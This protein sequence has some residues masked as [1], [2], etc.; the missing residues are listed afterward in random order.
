[1]AGCGR[2]GWAAALALVV[3]TAACADDDD[4]AGG[5]GRTGGTE[6]TGS[7]VTE[8]ADPADAATT[9]PTT[10]APTASSAEEPADPGDAEAGDAVPSDLVPVPALEGPITG[11]TRGASAN[12]MPIG[13]AEEAGY[14]EEEWFLTGEARAF[15]L[16][17]PAG[18]DGAWTAEP[19][20]VAPYRTR[21]IVRRPADPD[22]FSGT[23]VV[24][25]LNVTAGRD[26]DP[27]FGFLHPELLRSGYAYVGVSAQ[28]G[29]L[30]G[31]GMTLEVPGVDPDQIAPLQTWDPERYGSLDHPGDAFSYDIFSQ[32]AQAVL[33]HGE[34]DPLDGLAVDHVL[35]MGE[36]QSAFRLVTYVDAVH[37]VSQ[38]F[39]GFLLHSRGGFGAPLSDDPADAIPETVTIRTDLQEP[40]LQFE[41]ET[42]LVRLGFLAA[43]QPDGDSVVTW[44]V[45]GTAHA[46]RS[47]LEYG[48]ASGEARGSSGGFDASTFCGSVN[49]GPQAPVLRAALVALRAWA[50]ES[51]PPPT[52]PPIEVVDGAIARD[53]DGIALG[54]IRTPAVDV[55]VSVET[56]LSTAESILC[57]LFGSSTP[58]PQEELVARYGD[59]ATYVEQVTASADAAVAAGFLLPVD[60]DAVVADAEA[61]ARGW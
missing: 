60:R 31:G 28:A 39:E 34:V 53:A 42:D 38:V 20:E 43:R 44:E 26:S 30:V 19:G 36:S 40:V 33:A 23:L 14:V 2:A 10:A 5:S 49:D 15:H 37:P 21:V 51:T 25:W 4:D 22:D 52:A 3:L 11:G 8:P 29:G 24:E 55:P 32:A 45:A 46:D 58:F 59:G 6:A 50:V 47:T 56:G 57:S 9:A 54:G 48:A 13:L 12:P 17:G 41:T 27:D 18:S 61:T 7:A 35:A 16:T 1:V